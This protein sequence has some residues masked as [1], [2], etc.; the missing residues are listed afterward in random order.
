MIKSRNERLVC[1]VQLYYG[2]KVNEG[3]TSSTLVTLQDDPVV[4]IIHFEGM[5]L[6]DLCPNE[7]FILNRE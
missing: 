7:F 3:T 4:E 2:A 6:N 5:G 1:H